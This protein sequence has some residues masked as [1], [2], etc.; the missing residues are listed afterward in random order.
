VQT[1]RFIFRYYINISFYILFR[2]VLI[3]TLPVSLSSLPGVKRSTALVI[4]F[5]S[6]ILRKSD[7]RYF[8]L[9]LRYIT[10]CYSRL[11]FIILVTH[12]F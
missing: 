10:A 9:Y 5:I 6:S 2:T 7:P 11:N 8:L 4:Y 1:L 12:A 3:V